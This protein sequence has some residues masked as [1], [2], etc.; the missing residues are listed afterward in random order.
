MAKTTGAGD[1]YERI[2]FSSQGTASDGAGGTTTVFAEQFTRRAAY[3]HLRGGEAVLAAR[4]EGRHT[5][6][7][8]VWRDSQTRTVTTDWRIEDKRSGDLFNIRDIT[9]SDD[10]LWLDFLCE[11][12]VA[13]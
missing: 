9:P 4:L 1:L 10:R 12:G 11:K 8:R 7:I 6:I 2:G 13:T 5:Q 3:I